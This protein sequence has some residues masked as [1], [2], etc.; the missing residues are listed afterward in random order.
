MPR[1]S[2]SLWMRRP[3]PRF[4]SAHWTW[5]LVF[6]CA[7]FPFLMRL[8]LDVNTVNKQA[9]H[10][11]YQGWAW[12]PEAASA[13]RGAKTIVFER[14]RKRDLFDD[15]F[16]AEL[17]GDFQ[18]AEMGGDLRVRA[19]FQKDKEL[20]ARIE[21]AEGTSENW[22]AW[23]G[24]A[25]LSNNG[26]LLGLWTAFLLFILGKSLGFVLGSALVLLLAWQVRWDFLRI[27]GHVVDSLIAWSR[28][29][30]LRWQAHDVSHLDLSFVAL[31]VALLWIPLSLGLRAFFASR[32]GNRFK[33]M[34]ASVIAAFAVE[35]LVLWVSSGLAA[36]PADASWW[37]VYLGS[38]VFRFLSWAFFFSQLVKGPE[39]H[40]EGER[41]PELVPETDDSETENEQPWKRAAF[42]PAAFV[43]AGGW[44]WLRAV[45]V[46]DS[47]TSL[48]RLKAFL[49][50]LLLSAVLGSR[51][52]AILLGV[53]VLCVVAPP[54]EGHWNAA[55]TYGFFMDGL[56]LGWWITPLKGE[57]PVV[58]FPRVGP[59]FLL[60]SVF[61]W[62]LGVFLYTAGVPLAI[63]WLSLLLAI[64][65]YGQVTSS[66]RWVGLR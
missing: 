65:A 5:A 47:G 31:G 34:R 60:C 10:A 53:L 52:A 45:L 56:V 48:L 64:W 49:T 13:R 63:C 41:L 17:Q 39:S 32:D 1:F 21:W 7:F 22:H 42:L 16:L 50:A 15:Y 18:V 11:L 61:A 6:L 8:G 57:W 23:S 44:E 62:V 66:R 43:L 4:K 46:V 24:S 20:H 3:R 28:E 55:A 2:K 35:P 58:P 30:S 14:Q 19:F 29:L 33:R 9:L 51:V 54:T 36:W 27:P 38:L 37:K 26:V 59:T 12:S 40:P 25:R